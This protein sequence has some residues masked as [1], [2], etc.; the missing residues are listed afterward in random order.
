M[1]TRPTHRGSTITTPAI[2][3][4]LDLLG[5][6]F[7]GSIALSSDQMSTI[8]KIYGFELE[9]PN[10]KPEPPIP[11]KR[12]DFNYTWDF[13][14]GIRKYKRELD[15]YNKWVD[16]IELMQ[17]GADMNVIRAAQADG[18]RIVAWLAKYVET[19]KDPLKLV[20]QLAAEAGFDVS[21]EDLEWAETE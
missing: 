10:K 5:Y 1:D 4:M 18:L 15:A 19:G 7:F 14:E 20:I 17:A 9:K 21:C 2:K 16:P 11:P 6:Q 12:E 13:E 8:Q 3:D